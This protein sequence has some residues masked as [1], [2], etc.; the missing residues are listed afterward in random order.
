ML[1][2]SIFSVMAINNNL[3]WRPSRKVTFQAFRIR[4]GNRKRIKNIEQMMSVY[5]LF[6][7]FICCDFLSYFANLQLLFLFFFFG[8]M[9]EI[10]LQCLADE[11]ESKA[12]RAMRKSFSQLPD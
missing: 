4:A 8:G 9:G 1:F 6:K 12:K 3:T 10:H 7:S 5:P 2:S 11:M